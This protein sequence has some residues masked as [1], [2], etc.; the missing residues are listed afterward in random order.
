MMGAFGMQSMK[1]G[2]PGYSWPPHGQ[3]QHGVGVGLAPPP[4][5]G[6]NLAAQM[7]MPLA[8]AGSGTPRMAS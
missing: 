3:Q 4:V 1:T 7:G 6:A 2:Q 8:A 5:S